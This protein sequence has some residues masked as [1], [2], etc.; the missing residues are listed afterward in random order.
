[1]INMNNVY[2]I[3]TGKLLNFKFH[4][5]ENHVVSLYNCDSCGGSEVTEVCGECA[6]DSTVCESCHDHYLEQKVK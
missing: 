1:M 4:E 6:A 2:S 3:L 5:Y